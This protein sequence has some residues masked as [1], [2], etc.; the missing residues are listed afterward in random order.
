[1][2]K[3]S[4]VFAGAIMGAGLTGAVTQ[5][6]LFSSTHAIAASAAVYRSR[7]AGA[8]WEACRKGLPQQDAF[9]G[10]YRQAMG[11]DQH[12]QAGVYF[13]TSTGNLFVSADE[14]DTWQQAASFLPAIL[15]VEAVTLPD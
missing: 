13:G 7:D 4:L 3:V 8:T 2:R 6:G 15:S 14:G 10:V 1:M 12:P 5:T 11:T 9:F